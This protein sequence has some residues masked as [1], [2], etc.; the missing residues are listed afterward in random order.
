[1]LWQVMFITKSRSNFK[2]QELKI[3]RYIMHMYKYKNVLEN[4]F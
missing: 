3:D 1:M 2:T 4:T